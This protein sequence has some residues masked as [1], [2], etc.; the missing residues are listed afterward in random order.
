[1]ATRHDAL[2][3]D[4]EERGILLEAPDSPSSRRP[5]FSG[6]AISPRRLHRV[7]R[8]TL[9]T[10]LGTIVF[11]VLVYASSFTA[12][13]ARFHS[14]AAR[15]WHGQKPTPAGRIY[16]R[17]GG[18]GWEGLGSVIQRFK[19]SIV[20]SMALDS[21][22]MI[23]DIMSEHG[24]STSQLINGVVTNVSSI[25]MSHPCSIQDHLWDNSKRKNI[26]A[27]FC[28]RKPSQ[29]DL[30][31]L[32]KN[33]EGCTVILDS[34][35]NEV[36][37][38]LNG[39]IHGWLRERLGAVPDSP[40]DPNRITVGVHI[41][42]GDSAGQFRGS[43]QL[44]NVNTVLK[45]LAAQFG[46]DKLDVTIAME[47]HDTKILEQVAV[48]KYRLVDSGNG[49][50]DMF[51]LADNNVLVLGGSSYAAMAHLLAPRGLSIVEGPGELKFDNT[52]S[53]GR[54]T[55]TLWEYSHDV[56]KRLPHIMGEL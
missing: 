3:P 9:Y 47:N 10:G 38:H 1:M 49:I 27:E 23:T 54:E 55:V 4:H 51:T 53:F 20:L 7:G 41:R 28:Q 2:A 56:F 15:L 26:V 30:A 45:D 6:G 34:E 36:N 48:K 8:G 33:L 19:E 17:D 32:T 14:S 25:D 29:K 39:C 18:F 12:P 40:W 44:S 46:E 50:K 37:E 43:M 42:W 5:S 31:E 52:S 35:R 16:V 22:L 13:G 11:L 21:T 24:Y